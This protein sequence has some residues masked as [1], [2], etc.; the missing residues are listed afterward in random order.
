MLENGF[1]RSD[2]VQCFWNGFR[3]SIQQYHNDVGAFGIDFL[4]YY[5]CYIA[6]VSHLIEYY[7]PPVQDNLQT[8]LLDCKRAGDLPSLFRIAESHIIPQDQRWN[9]FAQF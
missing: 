4:K 5:C 9:H 3:Q 2:G 7:S 6:V 8:F 1:E